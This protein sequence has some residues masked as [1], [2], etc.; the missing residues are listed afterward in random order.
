MFNPVQRFF[1]LPE[2]F[3]FLLV[4]LLDLVSGGLL[5]YIGNAIKWG[6]KYPPLVSVLSGHNGGGEIANFDSRITKEFREFN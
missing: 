3:L 2:V 6:E 5:Y 1:L 4:Y